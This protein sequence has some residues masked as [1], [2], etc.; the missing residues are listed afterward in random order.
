MIIPSFASDDKNTISD[1]ATCCYKWDGWDGS[2]G[3]M[4]RMNTL[5]RAFQPPSTLRGD[6]N[7]P[8]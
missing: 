3:E 2:L 7:H 8:A 5:R 1:V 4:A 6:G